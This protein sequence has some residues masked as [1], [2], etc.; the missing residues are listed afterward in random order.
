MISW[1]K[2]EKIDTWH[3]GT[4]LGVLISCAGVGYEVQLLNREIELLNTTNNEMV[5]WVHQIQKD[6]GSQLIGFLEK[7][8]RDLFRKLISI[9]GIGPQLAISLLE[10]IKARKLI[11]VINNKDIDQLTSCPGIGSRTAERLVIELQHKLSGLIDS[12]SNNNKFN[13]VL[14]EEEEEEKAFPLRNE[15]RSALINLGYKSFEI[16]K[17]FKELEKR[18]EFVKSEDGQKKGTSKNVDFTTLLKETLFRIN[19]QTR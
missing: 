15:V 17:A 18:L 5:F 10:Q 19:K 4:R 12:K 8:E 16:D 9:N 11:L 3:N 6:D 2:G 14:R 13:S 7:L 1:L